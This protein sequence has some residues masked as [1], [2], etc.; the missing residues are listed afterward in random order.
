MTKILQTIEINNTKFYVE[1]NI[2]GFIKSKTTIANSNSENLHWILNNKS[3]GLIEYLTNR[4][5][6]LRDKIFN[7]IRDYN[8]LENKVLNYG[9]EQ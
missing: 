7:I 3:I 6:D 2:Q 8:V 9:R 1:N 5:P 4:D